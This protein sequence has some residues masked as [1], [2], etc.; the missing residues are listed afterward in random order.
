MNQAFG[1][2]GGGIGWVS[3]DSRLNINNPDDNTYNDNRPDNI[4]RE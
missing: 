1:S 3:A 4:K 2:E